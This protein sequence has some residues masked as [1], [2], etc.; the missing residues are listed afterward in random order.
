MNHIDQLTRWHGTHIFGMLLTLLREV[1]FDLQDLEFIDYQIKQFRPDIIYLGHITCM[2]RSLMPYLADCPVPIIYDEGGSGLIDAWGEKSI[3]YK[4][5]EEFFSR[6]TIMNALKKAFMKLVGK[7]S[8]NKIKTQWAWPCCLQIIFNSKLNYKNA[9]LK[10]VPVNDAVVIHSGIDIEKFSFRA[11]QSL[12]S[13]LCIVLPGRIEP[14][15]GQLDA[16][17]LIAKLKDE[18]IDGNLTF[19]GGTWS[20]KYFLSVED[21]IKKFDIQDMVTRMPMIT[22]EELIDLYH[23]SDICF[24]PSYHKTGFSRIPLEAM[25]CGCI[26]ISYG[27]EGSDEIIRNKQTGFIV[28]P[29][30][31][32]EMVNYI[33]EMISNPKNVRDL[34]LEARKEVVKNYAMQDYVDR[35]EKI[36]ISAAE[37]Y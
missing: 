15:K 23:G 16:V 10:G 24:F 25:A 18:G 5:V 34:T 8:N 9:I 12:G 28:E 31:Y 4:F 20:D 29:G 3:W 2:S 21:E 11:K 17:K 1:I 36:I 35:V 32:I 30:N 33:K 14:R 19:V 26:L 22:Q 27:N 13:P 37:C 7:L 6:D